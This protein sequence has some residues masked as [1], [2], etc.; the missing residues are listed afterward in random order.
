MDTT[1]WR[2]VGG[3]LG[4][5]LA[6]AAGVARADEPYQVAEKSVAQLQA[7]M[8]AGRITAEGLVRAY[9][10]RIEAIDR[11]GPTLRSVIVL[12][13]HALD[14]ARGLDAERRA[15]H[16]RGPLHGIPVLVKD[17]IETDD[18]TATTAG[19]LALRDNVT[20]RDAPVVRRLKDAGAVILGKTNLSEWANI[21]SDRS[22]SGW[23]GVGG[24]VKNPYALDRNACGSSS[25]TGAAIAASLAAVGV[26]TET[27]GS[28]TCPSSI[29]GLAGL[30]PTVGLVSRARVIPISHSQD[31]PGPMG[32]GVEDLA[33]LLTAMAGSDPADPA[34]AEADAHR[35][36]YLAALHGAS[37]QGKRLGVLDFATGLTPGTDAVF[38]QAVA[39]LK[40]QGAEVI[41]LKDYKPPKE[42]GEAELAV[43]LSELKSDLNAYLATTPVA[44]RTRTLAEVI[45][46]NR[47]HPRE[48]ALFG[49][50]LFEKANATAGPDDPAYLKARAD[51]L[52]MAG[53]E[54][55][56]KLIAEGRLDALIAPSFGPAYRTDL[57]TG[58]HGA[59]RASTLP[60]VAGYPH[61]TVPMGQVQGLPVGL[62][63]IGPAWS[64]AEMLTLGYAFE[65]AAQARKPPRYIP[66][67]EATQA[68]EDAAAPAR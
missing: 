48:L 7:D 66:S 43:L 21:R 67:L 8:T 19:S 38:A 15:G 40:A 56:D 1:I 20:L 45:A 2:G 39:L 54:G 9:V 46:F 57:V 34:T 36:D 17:N 18:G 63:F 22:I 32:R 58:D 27:D 68:L 6:M 33:V 52:R 47:D 12:N 60:A 44:V 25:G 35:A 26:G 37:L 3:A 5:V 29:G 59:G 28:V 51:S 65:Q 62:S 11:S 49:Q 64:D 55:I 16:L 4:V 50:E 10:A 53:A 61:L 14:D 41:E 13:P 30:K 23:S 24:L 42:L 31:T